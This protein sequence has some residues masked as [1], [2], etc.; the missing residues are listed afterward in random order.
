M[1]EYQYHVA[2]IVADDKR[3]P[4]GGR[5]VDWSGD[6]EGAQP[7]SVPL[8]SDGSEPATHWGCQV[9]VKT[10]VVEANALTALTTSTGAETLIVRSGVGTGDEQEHGDFWTFAASLNLQAAWSEV[11]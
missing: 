6:P 9:P 7:L 3:Q 11:I 4:A 5:I 8:S 2:I 1:T 10:S